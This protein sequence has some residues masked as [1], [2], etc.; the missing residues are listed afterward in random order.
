MLR[1]HLFV[2]GFSRHANCSFFGSVN[3]VLG[4]GLP[5]RFVVLCRILERVIQGV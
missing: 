2:L 1:R 3:K 5:N 4:T